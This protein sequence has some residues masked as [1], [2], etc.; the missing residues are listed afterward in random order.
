MTTQII[1]PS[2]GESVTEATIA[3]WFKAVGDA[4]SIDEPVLELETD[5]VSLEVNAAA[6]GHLAEIRAEPG[7]TVEVG[8]VLGII[9]DG[10][11]AKPAAAATDAAPATVARAPEKPLAPS[12]RRLV[13]EHRLPP[14]EFPATG[15]DG[16]LTK[17]DVLQ[18]IATPQPAAPPVPASPAAPAAPTAPP[19]SVVA[20]PAEPRPVGAREQRIRMT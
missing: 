1:V 13:E 9:A 18:A 10:A 6:A 15:K 17:G 20:P 8:A 7:A 16:R 14:S 2:L 3:K 19:R 11:G 5:K 4:V 12:V